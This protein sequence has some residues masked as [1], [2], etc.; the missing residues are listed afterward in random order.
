VRADGPN[1]KPKFKFKSIFVRIYSR[2]SAP[3]AVKVIHRLKSVLL[4][5][6][7]AITSDLMVA[8]R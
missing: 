4:P 2:K 1:V 6:V 3:V 8:G 7:L 5:L